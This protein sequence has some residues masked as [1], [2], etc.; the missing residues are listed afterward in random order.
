MFNWHRSTA[1]PMNA[2]VMEEFRAFLLAIRSVL[3][4]DRDSYLLSECTNKTVLDIGPCE[5]TIDY[6]QNERWFFRRARRVAKSIVGVDVNKELCDEIAA[7]GLDVR[8]MDAC[9]NAS[10]KEKFDVVLA[11]D[12]IEHVNNPASLL[13]FAKRHLSANGKIIVTTP[14][15][16]F[17]RYFFANFRKGMH[18]VNF[19]HT[20]WVTPTC[21][22]ELCRR[23]GLEFAEYIMVIKPRSFKYY[24][25][26]LLPFTKSQIEAWSKEYIY[27]LRLPSQA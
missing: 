9:S 22:N 19:E 4:V 12:V 1:D 11:G 18:M 17:Y 13:E 7:M 20:C 2:E 21:M 23:S 16:Y 5:H 24:M 25:M 8:H 27:F 3:F 14:N 10:L 26:K 6:V 15:P